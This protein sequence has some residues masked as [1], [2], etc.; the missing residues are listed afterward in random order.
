MSKK[1]EALA[2]AERIARSFGA[3]TSQIEQAKA[4]LS[5]V[6]GTDTQASAP[7]APA[8]RTFNV[9]VG[10][11]VLVSSHASQHDVEAAVRQAL[12]SAAARRSEV[13]SISVAGA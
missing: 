13:V 9:Q 12:E 8:T 3:S 2:V 1:S 4:E 5:R 11:E 6:W 7:A 10:V